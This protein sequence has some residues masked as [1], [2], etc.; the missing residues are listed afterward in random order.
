[1][2]DAW[3]CF[4]DMES[5]VADAASIEDYFG[6]FQSLDMSKAEADV[7]DVRMLQL[8][9]TRVYA[10][11]QP[12]AWVMRA[13]SDAFVKVLAGGDWCDEIRLP[14]VPMNAIRSAAASRNLEIFSAVEHRLRSDPDAKV[15]HV[16]AAVADQFN[17]SYETARD[18]YYPLRN[19]LRAELESDSFD[20]H[21]SDTSG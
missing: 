9:C 18:G 13:L 10:G 11:E 16:L 5:P 15:T 12:P 14:W 1:M 4:H 19:Q 6:R 3:E 17:C 8:F 2:K 7:F 20:K 21:R